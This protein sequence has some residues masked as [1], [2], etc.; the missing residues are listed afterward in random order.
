MCATTTAGK[1]ARTGTWDFWISLR[2]TVDGPEVTREP[3]TEPDLAD[4]VS[5]EFNAAAG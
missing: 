1:K 3:I 4:R 2:L 5:A